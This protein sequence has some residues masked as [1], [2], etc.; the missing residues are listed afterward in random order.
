MDLFSN[1]QDVL[2][3]RPELSAS[4]IPQLV[5]AEACFREALRL[6][7]PAVQISRDAV[8]HTVMK[9]RFVSGVVALQV[10]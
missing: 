1:V 2:G 8:H 9:V 3:G 10:G 5:V 6:H 4:D 7:P